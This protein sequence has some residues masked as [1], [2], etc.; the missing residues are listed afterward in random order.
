MNVIKSWAGMRI[1]YEIILEYSDYKE[2][3]LDRE[4]FTMDEKYLCSCVFRLEE[5]LKNDILPYIT[6]K[7]SRKSNN[8]SKTAESR[9]YFKY[10]PINKESIKIEGWKYEKK[11]INF[12]ESNSLCHQ[13]CSVNYIDNYST[14]FNTSGRKINDCYLEYH[15]DYDKYIYEN[16]KNY[17]HPIIS[18]KKSV[19]SENKIKK[20][21][22]I[23]IYNISF[24]GNVH[25]L[26]KNNL[27]SIFNG[28]RK[29]RIIAK[30]FNYAC[31]GEHIDMI[32]YVLKELYLILDKEKFIN[33][34]THYKWVNN[35]DIEIF[36]KKFIKCLI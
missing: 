5:I 29:K 8:E 33:C 32:K 6:N 2:I 1:P 17:I 26:R 19:P 20:R 7:I 4:P 11:D 16:R 12:L 28:S 22:E 18:L 3:N 23:L 10:H 15:P 27:F 24:S 14:N 34:I 31:F 25:L 36:L 21:A 9:G 13:L 30:S 35:N